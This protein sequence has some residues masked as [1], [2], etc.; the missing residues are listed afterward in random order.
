MPWNKKDFSLADQAVADHMMKLIQEALD[1]VH[2]LYPQRASL[3]AG[4]SLL[5]AGVLLLMELSG[6][7][8]A[9]KAVHALAQGIAE[10]SF[11]QGVERYRLPSH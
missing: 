8:Q 9:V 7:E 2:S 1:E 6:R 11:D 10:G 3:T 5:T 4:A